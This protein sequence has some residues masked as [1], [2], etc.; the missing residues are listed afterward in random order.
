MENIHFS[1]F[2]VANA[3]SLLLSLAQ[4][5]LFLYGGGKIGC[6]VETKKTNTNWNPVE[7]IIANYKDHETD[8][9]QHFRFG[10]LECYE[11]AMTWKEDIT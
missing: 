1:H 2:M 7:D 5:V 11:L 6:L 10:K 3:K 8:P 9:K 4:K